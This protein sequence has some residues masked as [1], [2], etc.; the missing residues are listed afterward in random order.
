MI[1]CRS[2]VRQVDRLQTE[3]VYRI[4]R[5]LSW[6]HSIAAR[7]ATGGG[8]RGDR[9]GAGPRCPA[10]SLIPI[11]RRGQD[12]VCASGVLL[13]G[14]GAPSRALAPALDRA[15][16]GQRQLGPHRLRV[17]HRIDRALRPRDAV[18]VEA[19]YDVRD[20]LE[21]AAA[22]L[23]RQRANLLPEIPETR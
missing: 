13:A 14:V 17:G 1:G 19:A 20:R 15:Q 21:L 8:D 4:V 7:T 12:C 22:A 11:R 2:G 5:I 18:A 16:V 23:L 6:R 3:Q 9:C 10:L